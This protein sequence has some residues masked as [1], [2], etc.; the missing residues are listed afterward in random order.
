MVS[1]GCQ[2][3]DQNGHSPAPR[4][5]TSE[6]RRHAD[7]GSQSMNQSRRFIPNAIREPR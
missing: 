4:A 7:E 6:P 3:P 5:A 2:R 1:G